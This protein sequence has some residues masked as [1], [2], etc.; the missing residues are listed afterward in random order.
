MTVTIKSGTTLKSGVTLKDNYQIVR[1][2]LILYVDGLKSPPIEDLVEVVI[3]GGFETGDFTGWTVINDVDGE[4]S[5]KSLGYISPH[6]G[7]YNLVGGQ[8]GQKCYISQAL[9]VEQDQTYTISFWLACDSPPGATIGSDFSLSFNDVTLLS[10]QNSDAFGWTQYTYEVVSPFPV[11]TL[12][13]GIRNDPSYYYIDSVSVT[14]PIRIWGDISGNGNNSTFTRGATIID[15]AWGSVQLTNVE[16][17]ATVQCVNVP[18]INIIS[19]TGS[20]FLAWVKPDGIQSDYTGIA[21]S[22]NA[23]NSAAG[24]NFT[25]NNNLSYHWGTEI[26]GYSSNLYVNSGT[27]T[28]IAVAISESTATVYRNLD[29][30][31][32]NHTTSTSDITNFTI[33]NDTAGEGTEFLRRYNGEV[34]SVILYNRALTSEELAQNYRATSTRFLE[35]K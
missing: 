18:S 9:S 5:V 30:A 28:M 29:S 22:R 31:T 23:N 10:L 34:G 24:L 20:T 14:H 15:D 27:W 3:N 13:F 35:Y 6:D 16:T 17:S 33:G 12:E 19:S 2:G 11:A 1:D 8:I 25:Y 26:Y 4:T 32:T 21:F 7:N